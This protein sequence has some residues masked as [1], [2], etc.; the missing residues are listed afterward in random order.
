MIALEEA[1]ATAGFYLAVCQEGIVHRNLL[2]IVAWDYLYDSD[3]AT[4]KS[5]K[6]KE[7]CSVNIIKSKKFYLP[8]TDTWFQ[9]FLPNIK[10]IKYRN[11][12]KL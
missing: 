6:N 1:G 3:L 4:C 5:V 8:K 9:K 11:F 12:I 2:F 10:Y 7:I